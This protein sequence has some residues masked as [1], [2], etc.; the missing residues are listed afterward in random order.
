MLCLCLNLMSESSRICS[1][2]LGLLLGSF[3]PYSS[4]VREAETMSWD[5]A[6][7]PEAKNL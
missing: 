4:A 3:E 6:S 7:S 5:H 2:A 1:I